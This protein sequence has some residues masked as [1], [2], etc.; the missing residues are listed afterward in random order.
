MEV[1]NNNILEL[2]YYFS[3]SSHDIDAIVWNK[4]ESELLAIA[5]EAASIL[6]ISLN[7]VAEPPENGDSKSFGK[8]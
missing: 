6:D 4:C 1:A 5:Y 7:L 2:H 3:D 8:H